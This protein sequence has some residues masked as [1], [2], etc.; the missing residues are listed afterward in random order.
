VSSLIL[1]YVFVYWDELIC[2]ALIG[3]VD[4]VFGAITC[5]FH[6]EGVGHINKSCAF[7]ELEVV[8]DELKS[9]IGVTVDLDVRALSY[10][11]EGV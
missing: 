2:L 6:F 1:G 3:G 5:P 10:I 9:A 7:V 8:V 11:C 4:I